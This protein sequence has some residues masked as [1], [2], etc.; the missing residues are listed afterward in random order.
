MGIYEFR[1]FRDLGYLEFGM[2]GD[3]GCRVFDE[4]RVRHG[5]G[6]GIEGIKGI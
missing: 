5:W 4:F 2:G 3:L 6:I 1:A